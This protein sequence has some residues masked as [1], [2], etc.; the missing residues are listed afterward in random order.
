M[1]GASDMGGV[2]HANLGSLRATES[3]TGD[4]ASCAPRPSHPR[5]LL[6][7]LATAGRENLDPDHVA[8]YDG[9]E[10]AN[11]TGEVAL[12][13][14]HGLDQGSEVVDLGAGTGQFALAVAAVC[15]RVSPSTSR[16]SC[17]PAF[18]P[19]WRR[20]GCRTSRSCRR[21]S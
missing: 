21:G 11:A 17:S 18:G 13:L 12:L 16:L 2:S 8:R 20:L 19:S 6:D 10:D 4:M 5:W 9:K 7:E 14:D 1:F 3:D 15:A